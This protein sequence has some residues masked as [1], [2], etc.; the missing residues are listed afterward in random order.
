LIY[1][2]FGSKGQHSRIAIGV[3]SLPMNSC[4]EIDIIAEIE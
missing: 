2:I 4:V 1:E 3:S